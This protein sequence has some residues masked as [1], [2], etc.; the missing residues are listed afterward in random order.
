M[1][2]RLLIGTDEAGYGPSLGPLVITATAWEIPEDLDC[3]SLWNPLSR[4]LTNAPS[5]KDQRLFVADSK[6]VYSPS[7]GIFDLETGVLSFLAAL[8]ARPG[9]DIELGSLLSGE[10]FDQMLQMQPDSAANGLELP[11]AADRDEIDEFRQQL[12]REFSSTG[13]RLTGVR[14][15]VLFPAEFN[16]RVS[17]ANSKGVVLSHSTLSLVRDLCPPH[18]V[19]GGTRKAAEF[20]DI[21]SDVHPG[22]AVSVFCDKHGGRNRYDEI[23]SDLF[24]DQ[25]VFRLEESTAVSRYRMGMAQFCFRTKAEELLPV[26]LASMVSKYLREILMI[27]FN[28]FW[29]QHVPGLKPTK[30]YP[31]DARRFREQIAEK[32]RELG[33][34]DER[35][36]RVR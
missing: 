33:I 6:Q 18:I 12:Q 31:L 1:P 28:Q 26:A 7:S 23:I 27:R 24:D 29:Q 8:G 34:S 36:W 25:F 15:C 35:Y 10:T 21:S 16:E 22:G 13:I 9:S 5:G 30:G 4:V 3:H 19:N 17:A 11:V 20:D 32:A 14:C 2:N